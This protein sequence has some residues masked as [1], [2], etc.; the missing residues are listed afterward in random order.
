MKSR[1]KN[2][3]QKVKVAVTPSHSPATAFNRLARKSFHFTLHGAV[4]HA[5]AVARN[6][7][8]IMNAAHSFRHAPHPGSITHTATAV[9]RNV[10]AAGRGWQPQRP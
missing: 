7:S 9:T 6:G 8:I 3:N 1:R 4:Y 2:K 10:A 5:L